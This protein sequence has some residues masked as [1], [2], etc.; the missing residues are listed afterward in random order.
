MREPMRVLV[1]DPCPDTRVSA[2]WLVRWW[3]H[4][5]QTAEDGCSALDVYWAYR[6]DTVLTELALPNTDGFRLARDL[7]R[8]AG[9]KAPLLAAVTCLGTAADRRRCREAGFDCHLLKPVEPNVLEQLLRGWAT[10]KSV[11]AEDRLEVF[12]PETLGSL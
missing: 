4:R 7:R 1:V 12:L 10:R 5:V 2:A 11:R 9:G 8:Q 6:P 3:G